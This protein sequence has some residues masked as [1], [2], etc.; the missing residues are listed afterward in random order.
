MYPFTIR[1]YVW[2]FSMKEI[3]VNNFFWILMPYVI[4]VYMHISGLSPI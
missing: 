4:M 1:N 2:E 3:N